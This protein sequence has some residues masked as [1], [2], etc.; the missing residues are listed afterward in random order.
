MADDKWFIRGVATDIRQRVTDIAE[1]RGQTVGRVVTDLLRDA[2]A[3]LTD[4]RQTTANDGVADRLDDIERRVAALE[5]EWAKASPPRHDHNGHTFGKGVS[6]ADTPRQP[7]VTETVTIA[8]DAP[9]PPASAIG[10]AP[11]K[12][13]RGRLTDHG[14]A[15]FARMVA[16]GAKTKDIAERFGAQTQN[17]ARMRKVYLGE[18]GKGPAEAGP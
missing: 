4:E 18:I 6:N 17:V 1:Q 3:R 16:A 7:T 11:L 5:A 10:D 2:L 12:D 9:E 14:K 8:E 13:G 15:E